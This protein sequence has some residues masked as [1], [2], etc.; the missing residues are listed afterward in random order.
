MRGQ[1]VTR[2]T[3]A[4]GQARQQFLVEVSE[5]LFATSPTISARLGAEHIRLNDGERQQSE[6]PICLACGIILIPGWSCRKTSRSL[7]K[8]KVDHNTCIKLTPR[9]YECDKCGT[10]TIIKPSRKI[11]RKD[12]RTIS[13]STTQLKP[14]Q[15]IASS[16]PAPSQRQELT[17]SHHQAPKD[18][19]QETGLSRN[20]EATPLSLVAPESTLA[21]QPLNAASKKRARTRKQGGL[22]ALLAQRK[23]ETGTQAGAGGGLDLMDFMKSV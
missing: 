7:T 8:A 6:S 22:Q 23:T 18:L 17:T 1:D 16:I 2:T 13:S 10:R 14:Q 9:F 3:S 20:I 11:T 4:A 19:A 21:A 5:R 15:S 12:H